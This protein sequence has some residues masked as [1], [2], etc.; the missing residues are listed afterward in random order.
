MK[1]L[2]TI[3]RLITSSSKEVLRSTA[4]AEDPTLAATAISRPSVCSN[5]TKLARAPRHS[6]RRNLRQR[7]DTFRSYFQGRA[8]QNKTISEEYQTHQEVLKLDI[9][10]NHGSAFELPG[11]EVEIHQTPDDMSYILWYEN[12]TNVEL[13]P[14][15]AELS[16]H[17]F[18][19]PLYE[20]YGSV[21]NPTVFQPLARPDS[22][23][24]TSIESCAQA[25][26]A[27]SRQTTSQR[28]SPISPNTPTANDYVATSQGNHAPPDVT[29][30][31][32]ESIALLTRY[33][34]HEPFVY[35]PVAHEMPVDFPSLDHGHQVFSGS[36]DDVDQ[37]ILNV[38]W[39]ENNY[40]QGNNQEHGLPVD[41][42][43][44][45]SGFQ[46][47]IAPAPC[48]MTL[49]Q[50]ARRNDVLLGTWESTGN[51]IWTRLSDHE[52]ARY[53]DAQAINTYLHK[54]SLDSRYSFSHHHHVGMDSLAHSGINPTEQKEWL[55][56][57]CG[58]CDEEFTGQY[59]SGNMK[60]HSQKHRLDNKTAYRCHL[61]DNSYKRSDAL[62]HHERQKHPNSA[63]VRPRK[64]P[65]RMLGLL[66][67]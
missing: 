61:C 5:C 65:A 64:R 44:F 33:G 25:T 66:D 16:T 15:T 22:H 19:K 1:P 34:I 21:P 50:S 3:N 51:S 42:M 4:P 47:V 32:N 7:F 40:Q 67:V 9:E 41:P 13:P 30:S 31:P 59:A 12:S 6:L 45:Q 56:V 10:M 57:K 54:P 53:V 49:G 8:R 18:I 28:S 48:S 37:S 55:P 35:R 14:Q 29:V 60:R 62:R 24:N 11:Y 23:L 20:L 46:Q 43:V 52:S 38:Q 26:P 58:H 2:L 17:E 39:A 36:V 27:M 63:I